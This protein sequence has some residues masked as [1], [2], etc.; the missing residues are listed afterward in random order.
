MRPELVRKSRRLAQVLRHSPARW[1]LTLDPQGWCH[2]ADLTRG[3]EA[4]GEPVSLDELL[5][6]VATNDKR[7]FVLSTDGG[8]IRAAQGHSVPVELRL[9]DIPPPSVLYHGTVRKH[10]AAILRDG[11]LPMTRHAVHLSATKETALSVGGRRGPAVVLVVDSH[12]MHRDGRKFQL[13]ENGVWLTDFVPPRY[14]R[15]S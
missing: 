9:L 4:H 14:L 15:H 1:G 8:R 5:E 2:V 12:S 11:L 7:R 10:V 13:S 6:I 3:A